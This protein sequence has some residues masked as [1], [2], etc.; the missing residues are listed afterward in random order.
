MSVLI[1]LHIS[2][3]TLGLILGPFVLRAIKGKPAHRFLGWLYVAVMTAL[4]LSGVASIVETGR[5]T[6]FGLFAVFATV[7]V[8]GGLLAVWRVTEHRD[9]S[10]I[11]AHYYFM[12]WSYAGLVLALVAQVSVTTI[13]LGWMTPSYGFTLTGILFVAT[14][15]IAWTWIERRSPP[16]I[17]RARG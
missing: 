8:V 5:L 12:V 2:L 9:P 3:A 11:R 16:V 13:R 4:V 7:Q 15:A 1:G 6:F 14:T 17:E 10:Y